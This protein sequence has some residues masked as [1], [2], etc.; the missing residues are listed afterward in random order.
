M[1][2]REIVTTRIV[3]ALIAITFV[4]V[5]IIAVLIFRAN[6]LQKHQDIISLK[7]ISMLLEVV[8][9]EEEFYG[10]KGNYTEDW[11]TL[12]S[13]ASNAF[14][15]PLQDDFIN[16]TSV[17][18]FRYRLHATDKEQELHIL[19]ESSLMVPDDTGRY[20]YIVAG[21]NRNLK[22]SYLVIFLATRD[23]IPINSFW[24]SILAYIKEDALVYYESRNL[25]DYIHQDRINTIHR[26]DILVNWSSNVEPE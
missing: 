12:F 15:K 25:Y 1:S 22:K 2:I 26:K 11:V 14:P 4:V 18:G 7:A 24:D 17:D 21:M 8:I 19:G 3:M 5:I 10:N 23:E 13:E 16:N 9:V 20:H 6:R